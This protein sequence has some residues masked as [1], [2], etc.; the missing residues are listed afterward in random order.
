MANELERK[1]AK[2]NQLDKTQLELEKLRHSKIELNE[3]LTAEFEKRH[4]EQFENERKRIEKSVIEQS[5]MKITERNRVINSLN[6]QLKDVQRKAEQ[7]IVDVS[8]TERL[9][10]SFIRCGPMGLSMCFP[11]KTQGLAKSFKVSVFSLS[12]LS[13]KALMNFGA[14]TCCL[15][16][17]SLRIL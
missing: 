13:V 3:S 7:E 8:E 2:L 9:R 4:N 17:Q 11:L 14:D 5:E 15:S 10:E 12:I 6:D 16:G 1:Y